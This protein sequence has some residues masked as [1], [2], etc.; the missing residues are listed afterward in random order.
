M[1]RKVPIKLNTANALRLLGRLYANPS[2]AIKEHVSNAIDE[3]LKYKQAGQA[4][5]TCQVNYIMDKD[6]IAIEY[7]YGM[8]KD[9]FEDRLG[10][11]ADSIKKQMDISQVGELGIGIFSFLQIGKKCVF[12]T[13]KTYQDDTL[14]VT[15]RDGSDDAEFEPVTKKEEL[16]QPGIK[17][18]ISQLLSDP[19]K[20]RGPLSPERLQRVFS[21]MFDHHLKSGD[22]AIKIISKG[23][24]YQVEP[25]KIE[26]PRLGVRYRE[27]CLSKDFT[28]KF[29]LDI[30]FDPSGKGRVGIRH[31]KVRVVDDIKQLQAY[32]LEESVLA[33][34]YV[35]GFIDAD[36]LKVL[37]GRS[38]FDENEDWISFLDELYKITGFI[39][40]EVEILKQQEN[41]K[42]L[43]E[44]QKKAIEIAS[45]ILDMEEFKDLEIL[46][47][48]GTRER[49]PKLP[50]N[51]FD[52]VPPAVR[53][54]VN[55]RAHL[56]LKAMVPATIPDGSLV[57]VSVGNPSISLES[58]DFT[59][60]EE[61]GVNG[62]VCTRVYFTGR[63]R[64]SV[65]A[66]VIASAYGVH[67]QAKA[68]VMI[69][70]LGPS[71]GLRTPGAEGREGPRINYQE[72]FFEEGPKKH[73]RFLSGIVQVNKGNEDYK[74]EMTGSDSEKLAYATLMI[75]K[76]T[77]TYNDK[78]GAADDYLE[79]ILMF[80]FRLKSRIGGTGSV[81]GK[82]PRGRPRKLQSV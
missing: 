59:M 15:L 75:G 6:K 53:A 35:K 42:K 43:T 40:E 12:L 45:E 46:R 20:P 77:I 54:D 71:K 49:E 21:E 13:R 73:S 8:N 31:T 68:R 82:R 81:L 62:I 33:G 69:A 22:L 57:T 61:D 27:L 52:F 28:K 32:G 50:P 5:A 47:G 38:G 66:T 63:E 19:T 64:L 34:G 80:L 7:P 67:H 16:P 4:V 3:H 14:K 65:P 56:L 41:E 2:D 26:L 78:T 55:Q 9:E 39:E 23:H 25:L 51:G 17:I 76:E 44:I 11:V 72:V 36:F 60:R 48:L 10:R 1:S 79:K 30:Y 18:T 24:S 37:P 58:T 74:Q 29:S 70:E